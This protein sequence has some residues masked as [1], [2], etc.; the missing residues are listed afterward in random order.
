MFQEWTNFGWLPIRNDLTAEN[1]REVVCATTRCRI[2]CCQ[3]GVLLPRHLPL[4][5]HAFHEQTWDDQDPIGQCLRHIASVLLLFTASR[6][7]SLVGQVR[8]VDL[9]QFREGCESPPGS[10]GRRSCSCTGRLEH[11]SSSPQRC[12]VWRRRNSR[13]HTPCC[14]GLKRFHDCGRH[15]P[16]GFVAALIVAIVSER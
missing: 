1:Y 15:R 4:C 6:G 14:T 2:V 13:T 16:P 7:P 12:L 3:S 5:P 9:S 10:D 11:L 8:A